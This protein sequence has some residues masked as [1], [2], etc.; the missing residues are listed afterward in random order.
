MIENF[1]EEESMLQL[2]EEVERFVAKTNKRW[3]ER[4]QVWE[5]PEMPGIDGE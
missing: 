4:K 5:I 2:V 1:K 3:W